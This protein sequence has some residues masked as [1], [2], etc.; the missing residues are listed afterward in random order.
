MWVHN[1]LVIRHYVPLVW[2]L[3]GGAHSVPYIRNIYHL[4]TF[5]WCALPRNKCTHTHTHTDNGTGTRSHA[6]ITSRIHPS[7]LLPLS[8]LPQRKITHH[9]HRVVV[10]SVCSLWYAPP[11]LG[12]PKSP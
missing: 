11:P 2:R 12:A 1:E 8:S 9:P 6:P 7:S 3:I 10:C 5:S 4:C